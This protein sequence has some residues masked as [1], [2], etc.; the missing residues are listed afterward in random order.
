[1]SLLIT[2]GGQISRH[3]TPFRGPAALSGMW[4][5]VMNARRS[6]RLAVSGLLALAWCWSLVRLAFVPGRTGPLEQGIAVSGWS[7]SLL[8]VHVSR[9]RQARSRRPAP[10]R[11]ALLTCPHPVAASVDRAETVDFPGVPN[12]PT[13]HSWGSAFDGARPPRT[14][15]LRGPLPPPRRP[16]CGAVRPAA[17]Q[18]VPAGATA[19]SALPR[20]D[21][22]TGWPPGAGAGPR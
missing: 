4:E 1:M 21:R 11:P 15:G 16:A 8:P 17:P 14:P 7:L 5:A 6:L 10:S 18:R 3:R 12:A 9:R 20:Y 22:R 2:A 19:V 13:A